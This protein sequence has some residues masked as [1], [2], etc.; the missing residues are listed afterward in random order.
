MEFDY[1]HI[2]EQLMLGNHTVRCTEE[3]WSRIWAELSIEQILIKPLKG[4]GGVIGKGMTDNV[5]RVWAKTMHKCEE[6]SKLLNDIVSATFESQT[7]KVMHPGRIKGDDIDFTE[8]QSWHRSSNPVTHGEHLVCLDSGLVGQMNQ[9]NCDRLEEIC[10]S[11]QRH[12]DGKHFESCSFKRKD[13]KINF[14]SL[15]SSVIIGKEDVAI[16]H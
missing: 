9:V 7:H 15:Y 5:L 6:M 16:D 13:Q 4:R 10:A 1:P 12:M 14:Q 3:I 11:I 2:F 8:N